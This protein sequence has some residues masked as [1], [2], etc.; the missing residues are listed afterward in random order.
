MQG[1][2]PAQVNVRGCP[3][4]ACTTIFGYPTRGSGFDG[5]NFLC[6][7]DSLPVEMQLIEFILTSREEVA[8][9]ARPPES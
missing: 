4:Q 9:K 8:P 6:S 7:I 3:R 1:Y 2:C 5:L